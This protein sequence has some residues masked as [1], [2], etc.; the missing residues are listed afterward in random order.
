MEIKLYKSY[1]SD[2]YKRNYQIISEITTLDAIGSYKSTVT[3]DDTLGRDT[4]F[5]FDYSDSKGIVVTLTAPSGGNFNTMSQ[6]ASHDDKFLIYR[7]KF[8]GII[9]VYT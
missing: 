6:E 4:E 1:I 8:P 3:V 7:F 5:K 9:E 2:P